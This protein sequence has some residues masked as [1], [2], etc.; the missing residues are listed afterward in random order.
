MTAKVIAADRLSAMKGALL[1][2]AR[3]ARVMAARALD[4]RAASDEPGG[5]CRADCPH[6][7]H[8]A[9]TALGEEA[10]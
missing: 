1:A 8:N 5:P 6:P 4:E 7:T 10:S 9:S 2:R 3:S